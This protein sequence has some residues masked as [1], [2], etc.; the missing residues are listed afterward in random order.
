MNKSR[1]LQYCLEDEVNFLEDDH[2]IV[3]L[4]E[5]TRL[6]EASV[7]GIL[8]FI[9]EDKADFGQGL[10]VYAADSVRFKSRSMKLQNSICTVADSFRVADDLGKMRTQLKV[11]KK[12]IFGWKGSY[13]VCRAGAE[14]RVG[15]DNGPEGSKA[16]D[17]FFAI[18][19]LDSWPEFKFGF[20]EG[21]MREKS[22]F[23]FE[24]FFKQRKR[25][26]QGIYMVVMSDKIGRK[27]KI[28]LSMSLFAWLTLPLSTLNVF[29]APRFPFSLGILLDFGLSFLG[30]VALAM[31]TCGYIRQFPIHRFSW[32]RSLLVFPQIVVSSTFS[33]IVEN[34]AVCTMW[35]GDWYGFYIV[36]KE[37]EQDHQVDLV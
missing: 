29:L 18:L 35:F 12:A 20:I 9:T 17:C 5:E 8:N 23:T 1:A 27:S 31:Y 24:D 3:H 34:L 33:I 19:A 14:K 25:W 22:P 37:V 36:Q 21:E 4:D 16:E 13:V 6:T 2:W 11:L 28:L 30:S 32:P 10:I 26:M 7:K 15:F